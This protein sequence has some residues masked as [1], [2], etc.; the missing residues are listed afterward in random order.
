MKG[1]LFQRVEVPCRQTSSRPSSYRERSWRSPG[2]AGGFCSDA[3]GWLANA[4]ATMSPGRAGGC[5]WV[6]NIL[7]CASGWCGYLWRAMLGEPG[8]S[9][10]DLDRHARQGLEAGIGADGVEIG[11]LVDEYAVLVF[12]LKGSLQIG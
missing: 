5:T 11:L 12:Q 7:T 2:F 4:F 8:Q 1:S 10:H 3:G 6:R 9:P